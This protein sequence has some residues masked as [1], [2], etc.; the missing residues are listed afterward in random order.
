MK[1]KLDIYKILGTE[2]NS[3][4]DWG[5]GHSYVSDPDFNEAIKQLESRYQSRDHRKTVESGQEKLFSNEPVAKPAE[6]VREISEN[7]FVQPEKK[8]AAPVKN[9]KRPEKRKKVKKPGFLK[10]RE[11]S[12]SKKMALL[13]WLTSIA[14]VL[15]FFTFVVN[16]PKVSGSSMEP[17]LQNGDRIVVNL[18][19]REYEA[20]DIIVF[21]TARGDKLVKR[22]IGV[23]GDVIKVTPDRELFVNG[24]VPEEDYI[25]TET[26]IT[27]ITVSYPV[28]VNDDS[29]FVLGDNR[30]NS[31]DSRNT[32]IGLVEKEDII[33]K[34]I[35][36][37]RKM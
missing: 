35:F 33:G 4:D 36:C 27:D 10:G 2:H 26:A 30:T 17:T 1:D 16:V 12:D 24:E 31:K 32:D 20:G 28:I 22:V 25:Y 11:F 8:T 19:A 3:D 13:K 14:V 9:N 37:W 18:L 5:Q 29:Y 15:L 34:V 6:V 7:S 21:E 23:S